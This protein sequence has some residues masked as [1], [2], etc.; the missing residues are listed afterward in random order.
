MYSQRCR[1]LRGFEARPSNDFKCP[2][3]AEHARAMIS[4]GLYAKTA[5][6]RFFGMRSNTKKPARA[7]SGFEA[8]SATISSAKRG[9]RNVF[10]RCPRVNM[11]YINIYMCVYIYICD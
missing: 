3:A 4:S 7:Q 10:A 2:E 8:R 1:A 9:L 11:I 6:G 5:L